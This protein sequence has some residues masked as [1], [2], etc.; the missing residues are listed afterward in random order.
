MAL[1]DGVCHGTSATQFG[2]RADVPG[3]YALGCHSKDGGC[4]YRKNETDPYPNEGFC[5][6]KVN[7]DYVT[8]SPT[9]TTSSTVPTPQPSTVPTALPT[10]SS[11][12]PTFRVVVSSSL[13]TATTSKSS[14][15]TL[16][17]AAG[18]DTDFDAR[19]SNWESKCRLEF[20]V[21]DNKAGSVTATKEQW[22]VFQYRLFV[23]PNT[24]ITMNG[25]TSMIA[26]METRLHAG[27]SRYFLSCTIEDPFE[28]RRFSVWSIDS[29]PPD[30]LYA[31]TC[32]EVDLLLLPSSNTANARLDD[33]RCVV[34]QAS[35]KFNVYFP[36][37]TRRVVRRGI[38]RDLYTQRHPNRVL[39]PQQDHVSFATD[40]D[41]V[42]I[43]AAG[44][45]F[46]NAMN[47]EEFNDPE[48]RGVRQT[49]FVGFVMEDNNPVHGSTIR[50]NNEEGG[51]ASANTI[52]LATQQRHNKQQD[53]T[54]TV[55]AGTIAIAVA[56]VCVLVVIVLVFRSR[57][58]RSDAYLKH[59]E[60]HSI[61]SDTSSSNEDASIAYLVQDDTTLLRDDDDDVGT[62]QS[63]TS[64]ER[65]DVHHCT[66]AYCEVCRR[67]QQ[68]ARQ[69]AND[70]IFISAPVS[71]AAVLAA[72]V[73]LPDLATSSQAT[74]TGMSGHHR[75]QHDPRPHYRRSILEDY[76][77][78]STPDSV[79][80]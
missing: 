42:V 30:S 23:A 41:P 67:Q 57:K 18:F 79:I 2:C 52:A 13:P 47:A 43:Q 19:S 3:H 4:Y 69:H 10:E 8:V 38:R 37:N 15:S 71:S 9:T 36:P 45:Y 7:D 78:Y 74:M 40:A 51:D 39:A 46:T 65:Q 60:E 14:T 6:Y 5:T 34:V 72:L 20:P 64:T 28:D 12:M 49:Q 16:A 31:E 62:A 26:E 58:R 68:Y 11:T 29:N 55:L 21:A 63:R 33:S 25:N 56:A 77:S 1:C 66:S 75:L 76:R 44:E 59:I 54:N 53:K 48:Q 61:Y 22:L 24:T 32:E 80:L 17:T 35:L 50:N 73:P 70:P 27:V